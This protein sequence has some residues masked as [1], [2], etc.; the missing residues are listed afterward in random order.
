MSHGHNE[1]QREILEELRQLTRV[2]V[3]LDDRIEEL[4]EEV[5]SLVHPKIS[6]PIVTSATVRVS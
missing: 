2:I 6:A 5:G 1:D 3:R 4:E